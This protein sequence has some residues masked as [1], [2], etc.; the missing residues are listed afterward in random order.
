MRFYAR[1]R[2]VRSALRQ[3]L[4]RVQERRRQAPS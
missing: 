3:D 4:E 2:M 1:G